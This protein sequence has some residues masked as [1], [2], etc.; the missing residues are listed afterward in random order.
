MH[1]S[2]DPYRDA[3]PLPTMRLGALS[4]QDDEH[5][6]L[7]DLFL[8]AD[9][10]HAQPALASPTR[11]ERVIVGS[12]P[13]SASAW[14]AAYA[15]QRA[16]ETG[17][18]VIFLSTTPGS[19]RAELVGDA[20]NLPLAPSSDLSPAMRAA[21]AAGASLCIVRTHP[22]ADEAGWVGHLTILT[23]HDTPALMSAYA[24]LKHFVGATSLRVIY[25][26]CDDGEAR[27][28]NARLARTLERFLPELPTPAWA[29]LPRAVAAPVRLL[30]NGPC[31][32]TLQQLADRWM[33]A[34]ADRANA[35]ETAP[36][37]HV[38]GA[39]APDRE[40]PGIG[41]EPRGNPFELGLSLLPHRCPDEP[42]VELACDAD[43]SLHLLLDASLVTDPVGTLLAASGWASRHADLLAAACPALRAP[44]AGATLHLISNDFARLRRYQ[45]TGVRLHLL[46]GG[47]RVAISE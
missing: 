25:V 13:V 2:R 31:G 32:L 17:R 30:C 46:A 3:I 47:E 12:T 1:S 24:T 22:S 27:L 43:G 38:A 5:A 41:R 34:D 19:L 18:P 9:T 4:S 33:S 11:C 16:K 29:S 44:D 23:G 20:P 26:G 10:T 6:S 15:A 28:A 8:D 7:A 14:A 39:L 45:H 35:Q 37:T 42:E 36:P 21:R 40:N